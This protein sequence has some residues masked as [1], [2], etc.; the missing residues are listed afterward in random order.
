MPSSSGSGFVC[1]SW[2]QPMCG[3]GRPGANLMRST[4]PGM[5]PRP[6]AGPSSELSNRIC[7]PRQTPSNGCLSV[8][9]SRARPDVRRRAI[10]SCA[11]PTP[12]RSTRDAR[13]IV[14]ASEVTRESAPRRPSATRRLVMFAPP[15]SMMTTAVMR[16]RSQHA[17]GGGQLVTLTAERHAQR[18]PDT[19][20]AGFDHVVRILT[21]DGDVDRGFQA[22]GQRAEEVWHEL[23]RQRTDGL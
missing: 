5:T 18:T 19:L 2:F 14:S 16:M 9:M 3:T 12:G 21:R 6:L 20:E 1:A 13:R 23:G 4:L 11:E 10:A 15:L 17:L 22:L 7:M 8:G